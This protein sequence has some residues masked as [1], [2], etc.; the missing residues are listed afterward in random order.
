[1]HPTADLVFLLA[2]IALALFTPLQ[3]WREFRRLA[4]EVK[5]DVPDARAR[6]F[7]SSMRIQWSVTVALLAWWF[8]LGNDPARV[9]LVPGWSDWEWLAVAVGAALC[10]LM[11]W[12]TQRAKRNPEQLT[13]L[14]P[15]LG[16]LEIMAPRTARESRLFDA[17]SITAGVCEETIYRGLLLGLLSEQI[18]LWPAALA[19]TLLFGLAHSYQGFSGI[20]RT[21]LAGALAVLLT[22]FSG[23]IFVALVVHAVVDMTQGRLIAAAV[24]GP[25]ER[26]PLAA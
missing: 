18:G 12:Q 25:E 23:S 8:L 26:A 11:I 17:L 14:R 4:A 20:V 24:A 5:A 19:S 10:G 15:Q 7:K 22:I 13:Q 3:G 6:V 21:T 16:E 2:L 9:G 1:M